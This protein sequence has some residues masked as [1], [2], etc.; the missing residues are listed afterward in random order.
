MFML[1]EGPNRHQKCHTLY[2]CWTYFRCY[3]LHHG[4]SGYS[5]KYV[6]DFK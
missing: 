2:V 4:L 5:A 3:V 6:N 1:G